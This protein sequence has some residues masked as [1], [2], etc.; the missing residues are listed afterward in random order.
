[1][2]ERVRRI[3]MRLKCYING[4]E[5]DVVQGATFS[6]EYNETLDSANIIIDQVPRIDDLNPYD[7]VF[8]YSVDEEQEFE[9][10]TN[11]NR[12][13]MSFDYELVKEEHKIRLFRTEMRNIYTRNVI[14]QNIEF[15][16]VRTGSNA[17]TSVN[18]YFTY[19]SSNDTFTMDLP[20][21]GYSY[22]LTRE[23]STSRYYSFDYSNHFNVA[24]FGFCSIVVSQ[25][26]ALKP[27]FYKHLLVY[28]F[29]E[30][31]LNP[32]KN[33]YKYKMLLC[34]ET[35]KLETIQLPNISVTQPLD[36]GLK[37][38]V[39][40]YVQQYVN[41]YNPKI[42]ISTSSYSNQWMYRP[43]Y[44]L[45]DDLYSIFKDV[46]CPDFSLNNP[47]LKDVLH[48]LFLTKD[49]I[50]V[51]KDDVIYAM[52]IS[53]RN[54]NFNTN[55]IHSIIGSK[56]LDNYA[57]NLKRTYANA[58]SGRNTA[59]RVEYLGFRN[60]SVA[61]MTLGNMRVETKYPMY[62]INHIY[63][64]YYKKAKIYK[65]EEGQEVF[66]R[67]MVFLCKQDIT[68]LV[69]LEQQRQL[70]S[71]DWNDFIQNPP[72][73]SGVI[74]EMSKYKLCTVGYS[75]GGNTIEGWGTQYKYP[76]GWWDVTKSY[77]EN[78]FRIIDVNIPYGIYTYGY[79]SK[80]L[81]EGEF[82]NVIQEE[83]PLNNI[84]T[85]FTGA[86]KLKSFFF[87]VDY[88]AFY[89][90]TVI[91]SKDIDKDDIVINDNSS[92][93]LTLLE[94]DGLFQKEKA[95]RF[96][97]MGFSIKANYENITGLQ[98]LGSVYD[99]DV[100]IYSREYQIWNNII[101]VSYNAT[102]DY[103]L[104]NY[105]T[106]VYSKHRPYA[107]ADYNQ[108]VIRAENKK[109]YIMISKST[110][111]YEDPNLAQDFDLRFNKFT[112]NYSFI[113]DIVSFAKPSKEATSID[114]FE[115]P[116]KINYG[117]IEYDGETYSSD[118]NTFVNG[119]SLCF[120]LSMWD[121]LSM[122]NY[123]K[124][125]SPEINGI[126]DIEDDYTGSIQ[127]FYSVIDDNAT[128]F[129]ERM[130]F[131][132]A[133][134]PPTEEFGD[135]VQESYQGIANDLYEKIFSLPKVENYDAKDII[136]NEYNICKDNKEV[137]D[138]TFQIEVFTNDKDVIFSE[139][140]MKL[141]DLNGTYNKINQDYTVKD[142]AGYSTTISMYC[143]TFYSSVASAHYYGPVVVLKI[144]RTL[145]DS[146]SVDTPVNATHNWNK[147]MY[148]STPLYGDSWTTW[149]VVG[150]DMSLLKIVSIEPNKIGINA[151]VVY[152]WR[153][154]LWGGS[155]TEAENKNLYFTKVDS[156]AR[157]DFTQDA[158][159]YYFTN[160]ETTI[161][162]ASAYFNNFAGSG[163]IMDRFA[164]NKL[165]GYGTTDIDGPTLEK[166][167]MLISDLEGA[168]K[169]YHKNMFIYLSNSELKN[170]LVYNEYQEGSMTFSNL[171]VADVVINEVKENSSEIVQDYVNTLNID[172]S[173]VPSTTK[174]LQVWYL[175]KPIDDT[176][177]YDN[178]TDMFTFPRSAP[179]Q[180][181]PYVEY[182]ELPLN[183]EL[184]YNFIVN[185]PEG[186]SIQGLDYSFDK[187]NHQLI[188]S[189]TSVS[190]G[191]SLTY[192]YRTKTTV[193]TPGTYH[194][195]FGVN[196][197]QDDFDRG[198]VD[199]YLSSI[200]RKDR[201]VYN[202][203]HLVV[204]EVNN[205]ADED[206]ELEY[207]KRQ[208]YMVK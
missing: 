100:I 32:T 13:F 162:G 143:S 19:N 172:L 148:D 164:D 175:D 112:D 110:L 84:V 120:N 97:N 27:S 86:S 159:N 122:G 165:I 200:S 28:Q 39:F 40:D 131:Y 167:D 102:K 121:N 106:S 46:Y 149:Y 91:T 194:F 141:S 170:T 45:S 37:R 50:P 208:Y 42:K 166:Y 128:G 95:N 59:R 174:S 71:E 115:Y 138:M 80:S 38:S 203:N 127:D 195:V 87:I 108:S 3:S 157:I 147:S 202:N 104:K 83:D 77:I 186:T 169:T 201:R 176:Y 160:V 161:F 81:E 68:P 152:T 184:V 72:V 20:Q 58:L 15:V 22:T 126:D 136:G 4:N 123:I 206:N 43:K 17:T 178:I 125:P 198:Y 85:P 137:I 21:L 155:S 18:A 93:S 11:S 187:E 142:V 2:M 156:L 132:V 179:E 192:T 73:G 173:D 197:T 92:S 207:G 163:F 124:V 44:T 47:S 177:T 145:F 1:M 193:V 119:Y 57:D 185:N 52:D 53:A 103:V 107:L 111:L 36:I 25:N 69:K 49:R 171:N 117:Y 133:H 30:E 150:F 134:I 55:N 6:D 41:L 65:V 135:V 140:L 64:C 79:I 78:I 168:S 23:S 70:L 9:G 90:G 14:S 67:D 62:K 35:K 154:G 188:I 26:S 76:I 196:L 12:R 181:I 10:Y 56:T 190:N 105:Y 204:G 63:M 74:D 180:G 118:I 153:H 94:K 5:Y 82:I 130:G 191:G 158:D 24:F 99:D 8:V 60:S 54:G 88:E 113:D 51:V 144:P 29:T 139:W 31:R 189:Y 96:G 89:N 129:T 146:L 66:S 182:V 199:I 75:I 7:D 101:K 34:S 16:F 151:N 116:D 48:Q 205:Y 98:E 114:R 61:L 33:L 183:T 109:T